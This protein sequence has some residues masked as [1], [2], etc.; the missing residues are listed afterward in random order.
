MIAHSGRD[1]STGCRTRRIVAAE[2]R[3]AKRPMTDPAVVPPSKPERVD[4]VPLVA[5]NVAPIAGMLFLGWSPPM[6]VALYALDTMFAVYAMSWLVIEHVTEAKS[7]D[8]GLVRALKFSA[9]ALVVG[10]FLSA[11]LIGPM[12]LM[13]AESD[14]VRSHPWTDRGFQGAL[15]AQA[16]GSLYALW[17]THRI[18]G[19]RDDDDAYLKRE[20]QFLVARWVVVLAVVFFGVATFLGETLGSAL[21]VVVYAGATIWFTLFPERANRM[22]FPDKTKP[23]KAADG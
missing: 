6:L 23:P 1:G 9:A 13:Y 4:L 7:P 20:F 16:A 15:A 12:V 22:F 14:W 8:R 5:S 11:I 3:P 18:L 10:T 17:R 21:I 2:T 19:E